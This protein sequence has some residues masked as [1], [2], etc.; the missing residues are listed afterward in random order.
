MWYTN[1]HGLYARFNANGNGCQYYD[2]AIL[3]ETLNRVD[4]S[5]DCGFNGQAGTGSRLE[6]IWVEHTKC[7]YWVGGNSH[8]SNGLV[9][10][11]CRFRDLYADG[12]N[13]CNGASNCTVE[14]SHL[15]NTGD[16]ALASWSPSSGGINTN[17]IFRFNTVQEP[18]RANCY[19]I[20]GGNSNKVEDNICADTLDYPGILIAQEFTSNPFYGTTS[21]QRDVLVRAGGNMW[22]IQQGA[23]KISV[24]DASISGFYFR[25]ISIT[26][27]T[28]AGI[29]FE[30]PNAVNSAVF[31]NI[32]IESPGTWGIQVGAGVDGT[33]NFDNV[34]VTSPGSGGLQKSGTATLNLVKGAGNSGW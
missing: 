32:A 30:G 13:F 21:V 14:Q 11:G 2:F 1:I 15:R 10:H 8:V 23:L 17:N 24:A 12:V 26:A 22:G 34:V 31:S 5:P 33:A 4:T 19:A 3:G 20:Y 6:N 18:W 27:A 7:G 29:Y 9:I 25:D 28:Y 16:D